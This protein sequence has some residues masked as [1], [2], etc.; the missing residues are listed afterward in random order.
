[1]CIPEAEVWDNSY[2]TDILLTKYRC[3]FIEKP[4]KELKYFVL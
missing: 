4:E 3:V 2:R 1:M